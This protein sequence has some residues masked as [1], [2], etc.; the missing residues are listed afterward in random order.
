MYLVQ[1]VFCQDMDR[2]QRPPQRVGD[3]REVAMQR[4][5]TDINAILNS[6]NLSEDEKIKRYTTVLQK[7]LVHAKQSDGEKNRLTLLMPTDETASHPLHFQDIASS[8]TPDNLIREFVTN[9]NVRFKKNAELLLSKMFQAKHITSWNDKGEF[10]YK[11]QVIPGSNLL[12]LVRGVTQSHTVTKRKIPQGW[13]P[14]LAAMAELNIPSS[15][16]G[17]ATNRE[18]LDRLKILPPD[19]T[20]PPSSSLLTPQKRTSDLRYSSLSAPGLTS[21]PGYLLNKRRGSLLLPSAD[22]L[23]L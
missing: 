8:D 9:V 18:S 5:D 11:K 13:S 22:W 20:T 12:D 2:L 3:I 4:L 15:V 1:N 14:F 7:Y 23:K 6:N 19:T 21:P 16:V 17:N 10:I